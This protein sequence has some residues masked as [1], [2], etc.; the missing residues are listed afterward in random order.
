[1]VGNFDAN[2]PDEAA[3]YTLVNGQGVWTIASGISPRTVT[4]AGRATSRNRATTMALAT[5]KSLS[6]AP[7]RDSSFQVPGSNGTDRPKIRFWVLGASPTS[8]ALSP[9][10]AT[11]TDNQIALLRLPGARDDR[12]GRVRP[13]HRGVHNSWPQRRLTVSGFLKGDIPAPADYLG[14]GSTQPVVFRPSTGQFIGAGGVVIA[15][16][17]QA[18]DIPL[19]AP[20]SYRMPSS[21]PPSTGSTGTGST[22]TGSTGTARQAQVRPGRAQ[23]AQVQSGQAQ[24]AQVQP[25]RAQQ[26]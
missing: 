18:G 13:E 6:I 3:V 24:Q 26:V 10:R 5:T 4:L 2:A 8:V 7:V 19:A 21:D 16:F 20:L 15:T 14:D 25:G 23:P 22:G 11:M 12:G 17:G 9:C 1:M